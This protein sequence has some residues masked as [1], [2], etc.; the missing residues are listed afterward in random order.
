MAS[1]H[2]IFSIYFQMHDFLKSERL[3]SLRFL[4]LNM[5]EIE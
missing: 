4:R 2:E 5:Q 1:V 3:C